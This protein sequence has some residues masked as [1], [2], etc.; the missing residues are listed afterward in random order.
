[1]SDVGLCRGDLEEQEEVPV[2]LPD[3]LTENESSVGFPCLED[4]E[5][6]GGSVSLYKDLDEVVV[7]KE[8]G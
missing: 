7:G 3:G 1:M 6:V 4:L 8:D 5:L 2:E